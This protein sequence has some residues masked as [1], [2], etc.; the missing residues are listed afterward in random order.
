MQTLYCTGLMYPLGR[1]DRSSHLDINPYLHAY[2]LRYMLNR[3]QQIAFC[4]YPNLIYEAE[5]QERA[6]MEGAK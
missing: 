3:R 4:Y 6:A 2:K 1:M 5:S